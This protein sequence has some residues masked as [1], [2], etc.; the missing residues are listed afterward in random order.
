MPQGESTGPLAG[1][2]VLDMTRVVAGPLAGQI[3]GD[4]GADVVKVERKGEGDDCRRV[5]PPWMT[6][7][8]GDDL[9]ESTYFQAVNRNKRSIAVDF[10]TPQGAEL[11]QRLAGQCDILLENY[12]PKTLEKYGLGYEQL[13]AINPRLIYCSLTGFGQ[14]GPYATRSG[15]DYLV[16]GMGGLM[17]VT[18]PADG[19]AGAGP[20]RVGIPLVDIFAGMNGVIGVLAALQHRNNTGLGQAIDISLLD[21]QMAS[22]LNIASSWL[23]SGVALGRTGNDHPSA[24]PYGV[25]PVADG[26]VIIATFNDREFV[27]L[28]QVL[29][30]PEWATDPRFA[31]NGARV[32]NRPLIK[33][34]VAE[35]I[36]H[37]TR[38]DCVAKLNAA[39]VSCGPIN[40]M[41]DLE[42]DQQVL[43]REMIVD[44]HH[45]RMGP[46]RT[47]GSPYKMSGS[48]V[49]YRLPPPL[50]GEHTEE[51]LKDLLDVTEG[52]L[53]ALRASGAI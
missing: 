45:P 1:I 34:L 11:L 36:A 41:P 25:Y 16:Q 40:S 24:A 5:G 23:N 8:D 49:T 4:L 42:H 37:M 51:V 17:N 19:E 29:G 7:P 22:L 47:V 3:F 2:R 18:G 27:R 30:H 14:T 50:M 12:R 6:T 28:A 26:H 52:D 10:A 38:A 20:T 33:S 35:A 46:I 32:A 39:T 13:K 15:Y 21:S 9:E 48:P 44:M 43:A 31:K 53:R